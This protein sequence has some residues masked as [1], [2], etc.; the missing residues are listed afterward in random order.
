MF[1]LRAL[2]HV[3][4]CWLSLTV[5]ACSVGGSTVL[6]HASFSNVKV[7][8]TDCSQFVLNRK[9]VMGKMIIL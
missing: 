5:F 8:K 4:G 2:G 3:C 1:V 9:H 7:P 6:Y